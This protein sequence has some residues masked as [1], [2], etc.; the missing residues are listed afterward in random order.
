MGLNVMYQ[1]PTKPSVWG[2][3]LNRWISYLIP[4][5]LIFLS[6]GLWLSLVSSP[7][8]YLQGETVRIM[9]VHVPASW[10]A[11]ATYFGM[12][13]LSIYAFIKQAPMAH[14]LTKAMAP[15]GALLCAI[16]LLT[17]SIW[18]KPTWGTWW[19]WDARL[20]SMFILFLLYLGYLLTVYQ[21]KP[22]TQALKTAAFIAI[23]GSLNLPIIKWSVTWWNTLHQPASIMRLAKPAIHQEML[24]PLGIMTVGFMAICLLLFCLNLKLLLNQRRLRTA[25]MRISRGSE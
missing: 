5:T 11:L 14:L 17:G 12:A 9:Y 24:I 3:Y 15:V 6:L 7:P 19:V 23:V 21:M 20:T 22:E 13:I 8:D 25:L 2:I 18:G 10:G 16:S 4:L 1:L